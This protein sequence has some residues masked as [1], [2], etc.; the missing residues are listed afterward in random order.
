MSDAVEPPRDPPPAYAVEAPRQAPAPY[1]TEEHPEPTPLSRVGFQ[2]ALRSGLSMSGGAVAHARPM[3]DELRFQLP[4]LIDI[5]A[6]VT[7]HLFLG[8]YTGMTFADGM[9][10]RL[11]AELQIHFAPTHFSN[12]WIGYGFGYEWGDGIR[13]PEYA[14]FMFGVDLRFSR[15]FGLGPFVDLTLGRYTHEDGNAIPETRG[16]EWFTLGLRVV[17]FP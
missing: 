15:S 8:G 14:R 13:G 7:R 16:H 4:L 11:G 1:E 9:G 6:K 12:P 3:S 2:A 5:G 10:A 17:A